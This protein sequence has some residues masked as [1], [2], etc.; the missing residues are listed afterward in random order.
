MEKTVPIEKYEAAIAQISALQL[1]LN[2]LKKLIFSS[3]QERFVTN[4]NPEQLS[5]GLDE[6]SEVQTAPETETITYDR[7]KRKA[8]PGRNALP[9][10]LPTEDIVIEPEEDT[11]DMVKIGE[12]I[13]E[14]ID[15]KPGILLKRRY[16]RPK[17]ARKEEQ[18]GEP[19]VV[20]APIP[21]RP[22][23]KSIAEAGL[24]AHL[25]VSKYVDHLPFYRQIKQ[26]KR[27]HDW[28]IHKSTLN[29][30][31][32][33][34]C[35]L[36]DPLYQA[37]LKRVM[38][39]NY[40]QA[41]ESPLKVQDSTKKGS[42]HQGYMWV[43]RNPVNGLVLFD[44]RKGRGMHGPKERLVDFEGQL[45][46]DGYRVYD[47]LANK[48]GG[49]IC[50][51]SCLAHIRRKFYQAKDHHPELANQALK[52]IQALYAL[53]RTYRDEKLNADQIAERRQVEAEPLLSELMNWVNKEHANNLS[54]GPIGKALFYANNQLPKLTAYLNNGRIQ[55]DNNLIENAIRPLALGRKNYLFAGSHQAAQRAA[56]LYS[57]FATCKTMGINPL[58]WLTD[59]L[60]RIPSTSI[61]EIHTL[62][63]HN[64]AEKLDKM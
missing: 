20:V 14:T 51:V 35:T 2:N 3:K 42:T 26:F 29:N 59:V 34:C 55:I 9:E 37:L 13:T 40:L 39:T 28:V 63:P 64:W 22:L 49:K 44:Y 16:I 17:F 27:N 38:D 53:E 15:Y 7:K 52:M 19:T 32:A 11:T 41:D 43:Y 56:M 62:L 57:F 36:I 31:F 45:Q 60:K 25:L 21:E 4:E 46:C 58:K 6:P 5:L 48:S 18:E 47:K 8:H 50:L 30:W 61:K 54:K 10:N 33:A 12:E 24:L 1:E 23:P